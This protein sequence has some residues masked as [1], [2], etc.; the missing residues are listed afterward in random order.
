MKR[1]KRMDSFTR[2]SYC[3]LFAALGIGALE[4]VLAVSAYVHMV[5]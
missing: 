5:N 2:F 1:Y 4:V 3:C